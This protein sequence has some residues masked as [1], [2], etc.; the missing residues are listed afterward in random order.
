MVRIREELI[1]VDAEAPVVATETVKQR[2]DPI[3]ATAGVT[4]SL[5]CMKEMRCLV[6]Q[7]EISCGIQGV[8]IYEEE[9][10][11]AHRTVVADEIR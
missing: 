11:N 4:E 5:G 2:I 6:C 3:L 1:G 9:A 7:E 8:V 10:I